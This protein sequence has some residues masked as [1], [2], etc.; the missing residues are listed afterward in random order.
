M[1]KRITIKNEGFTLIELLVVISVIMLLTTAGIFSFNIV[2]VQSRD[3]IRVGNINTITKSLAMYLND[4]GT[5]PISEEGECLGIVGAGASLLSEKTIVNVPVDPLWPTT[6]PN[7]VD[8]DGCADTGASNF[9]YYYITTDNNDYYL[10]Y[11]LESNSKSGNSGIHI[12]TSAGQ[13]E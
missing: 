4:N 7:P 2:R 12:V 9:C 13:V 10:N 5:Y 6:K 11:F 8:S 3:A 1:K